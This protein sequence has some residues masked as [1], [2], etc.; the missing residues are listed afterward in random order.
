MLTDRSSA[1]AVSRASLR[2]I[3]GVQLQRLGDLL[4][5]GHDRVERAHRVLEDHRHLGAEQLADLA[6]VQ[7]DQLA[8]HELHAAGAT[9]VGLGQQV[10]DRAGQDRLARPRLAHQPSVLPRS[11][12]KLT[13][14]TALTRPRGVRKWV[15]S[16]STSSNTPVAAGCSTLSC[17]SRLTETPL[18]PAVPRS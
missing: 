10:H 5:D 12:V 11:S 16:S 13:P 3:P 18:S 2:P 6:V 17:T 4:P 1:M 7:P 9:D 14:S 15:F 8:A